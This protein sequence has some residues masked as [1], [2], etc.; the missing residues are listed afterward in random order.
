MLL[1]ALISDTLNFFAKLG[2]YIYWNYK[3]VRITFSCQVSFK[4]KLERKVLFTGNTIITEN[5]TIGAFTYGHNVNINNAVI[6]R[7]CSIAPDVKIGL[8]EHD[9]TNSSTHPSTYDSKAFMEKV[10]KSIIGDH[11]WIGANAVILAGRS[12][13]SH[14]IVAAGAVVTKDIPEYE[15]WGGVPAKLIKT[16]IKINNE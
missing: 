13:G 3:G 12:I 2:S 1:K 14:S 6:G 16:I 9:I 11:V 8:D 4:S 10:G 15:L 5:S 7:F